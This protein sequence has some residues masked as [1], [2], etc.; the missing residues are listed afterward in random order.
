MS[1]ARKHFRTDRQRV[2]GLGSAKEGVGH[3]WSQRVTAIA[4]VP[5]MP[6]FVVT[7][8]RALGQ[9]LERVQEIY[10]HPFNAFVAILTITLVFRH[11]ALGL[12]VVIEDYVHDHALK[13]AAL[14]ASTLFTW[15]FLLAGVFG[16]AK[17]A[18]S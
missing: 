8:G 14:L 3:W 16:V 17:L 15:A 1:T 6:F 11:L 7:F 10:G 18:F 9:P 4:L 13:T 12:Q 5:L 2:A